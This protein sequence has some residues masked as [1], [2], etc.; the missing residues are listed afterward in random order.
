MGEL[1]P[2]LCK[3]SRW[4]SESYLAASLEAEIKYANGHGVFYTNQTG[5]NNLL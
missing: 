3:N 2:G 4:H 1:Q 5:I